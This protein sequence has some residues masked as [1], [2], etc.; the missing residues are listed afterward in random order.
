M[1]KSNSIT[2]SEK[3]V[4]NL[5]RD[6]Y[7]IFLKKIDERDGKGG[8]EPD[9]EYIENDKRIFVCE[10]KEY[11]AVNPSEKTGWEVTH[12]SD[13]SIEATRNS[14]A[15]NKV[16][17]SIHQAYKQ[18]QKYS[19]PKILIFLNHY[20]GLDVGDLDETYKGFGEYS[21]GYRK[22]IDTYYKRASEGK[23]KDEKVKIDLYI[24]ID[25]SN[26]NVNLESDKFYFRTVTDFGKNTYKKYFSNL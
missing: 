18:L 23:I 21:I 24:W 19:V 9:F 17:G 14:N 22:L 2:P 13:G 15:P 4:Q 11:E 6:R 3:Y 8:K 12:H 25:A 7:G 26:K 16:S 10:L 20:P 1:N 5:F